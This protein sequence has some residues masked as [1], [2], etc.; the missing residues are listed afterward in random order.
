EKQKALGGTCLNWGCI[1]TKAL[2]EHAHALKVIKGAKD[3]GVTGVTSPAIDIAQVHTR[4][5]RIVTTL[6]K[7][8]EFLFKKHKIAWIKGTARLTG[9]GGVDVVDG[10]RQSLVARRG[11]IVATGSAPGSVP[12]IDIDHT[13]LLPS[14]E[15]IHLKEVR[16]SLVRV[17]SVA[18]GV[19]FASIFNRFGS[20]VTIVE[21]RPR[22]VP[23]EDEATSA[24]LEKSFRKRGITSHPGAK[25]TAATAS[26]S[27]VDI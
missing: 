14:D 24:E 27:G 12:G 6:T 22:L 9:N 15:A 25:V 19:E 23:I 17:G 16:A 7:G 2:L 21:L 20:A 4:K 11:I 18:V 26:A 13:S 5:D 10:E 1:P 3:W 8:I